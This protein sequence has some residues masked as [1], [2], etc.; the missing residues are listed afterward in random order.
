MLLCGISAAALTNPET[1]EAR[2]AV[3]TAAMDPALSQ[4]VVS[5]CAMKGDGSI[6]VDIDADNMLVPAS[7]QAWRCIISARITVSRHR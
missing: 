3:E 5:I 7:A 1:D 2:A 6:I 4:A